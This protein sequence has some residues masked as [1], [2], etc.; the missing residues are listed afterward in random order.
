MARTKAQDFEE[1]KRLILDKAALVFAKDGMEKASMNRI[2]VSADISKSL[3]Y[4]YYPSKEALLYAIISSHLLE[5]EQALRHADRADQA[6]ITRLETLVITVL[7]VY[8]GADEKHQVQLN[9]LKTLPLH[10]QEEITLIMRRII[11]QFSDILIVIKPELAKEA[12]DYLFP[13]T[14]SL[15]GMLNW[16]YTWFR[17]EGKLSRHD[18]ARLATQLMLKGLDGLRLTPSPLHG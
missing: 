17:D 10:Q 11:R 15:F 2:A 18:Y 1:K 16:V 7:E 3:L 13:L 12:H 9:T 5:L 8:R 6:P 14:M 4:H